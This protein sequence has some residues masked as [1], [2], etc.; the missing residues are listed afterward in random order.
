MNTT[1]FCDFDGTIAEQDVFV[2]AV[3]Q[4]APE[5]TAELL[6]ELY[7]LRITLKDGVR[8]LL[9]SI[10]S[11]QYPAMIEYVKNQPMRSG[12]VE[13]L[14]FLDIQQIP[15]I[16]ISGG[17]VDIVKAVIGTE[18]TRRVAGI[19]AIEINCQS[20]YLQVNSAWEGETEL[21]AKVKVIQHYQVD[22]PI[23]IG[24]SITDFNMA[25][26]APIV[27][28][29]DRLA[30][31]LDEQHKPYLPWTDFFDI[32]DRLKSIILQSNRK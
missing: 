8:R 13:L 11:S 20:E 25:M 18:L 28:A 17:L 9:E 6:P 27:F 10:P 14:D 1:I 2:Q 22:K 16:I 12:F 21:I 5:L 19:Q 26:Y 15:L 31:Y 23:V 4:F 3:Q 32:R 24:D 29:R 7:A 30:T